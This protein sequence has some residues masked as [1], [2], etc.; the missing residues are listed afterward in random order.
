M[1]LVALIAVLVLGAAGASTAQDVYLRCEDA[2][3][4]LPVPPYVAFTEQDNTVKGHS[5]QRDALRIVERT[6]DA[7]SYVRTILDRRGQPAPA[8]P[9]VEEGAIFKG[10]DLYR[11]ADFPLAD[12][13]LR[14]THTRPGI[15]EAAGTPEPSPSA[16]PQIAS[17]RA[18]YVPYIIEDLG[19]TTVEGHD[20]YHFR[21]RPKRDA[22]HNVLREIWIDRESYL[23]RRYVA[24]RYVGGA[25]P[26]R[27]L[28]TVNTNVV[29]GYLVNR[30]ADGFFNVHRA[31]IV[32]FSGEGRWH[33]TNVS[34]P[35]DP[36]AWLFDGA[37]LES[38]KNAAPEL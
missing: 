3:N 22:G 23:P 14:R 11:I 27:Y 7:H 24:E 6:A 9:H 13:G 29:D 5:I 1:L 21:L 35:K 16:E 37:A 32:H 19:D 10:T 4:A 2:V 33:I 34:F 28:V 15:F 12:F 25:V 36:P 31:L 38:H 26:F 18:V 8:D 30:D 20:V 17:V